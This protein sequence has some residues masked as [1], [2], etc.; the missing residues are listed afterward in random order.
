MNL[1][2]GFGALLISALI[3]RI[4]S[5]RAFKRLDDQ[6][7]IKVMDGFAGMRTWSIVPLIVIV[8]LFVLGSVLGGLSSVIVVTIAWIAIVLYFIIIHIMV[9]RKLVSL[10]M[11]ELYVRQVMLSRWISYIGIVAMIIIV[12]Y[13]IY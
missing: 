4:I 12:L 9:K 5:E 13:V 6:S 3:A 1:A 10:G 8:I 7:K 2:L 11:A